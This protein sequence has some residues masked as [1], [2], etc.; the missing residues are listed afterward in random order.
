MLQKGPDYYLK[1]KKDN[2]YLTVEG[3]EDGARVVAKEKTKAQ[4]Q[5]FRLDHY[6]PDSQEYI[7]Y[8]YCGKVLDVA[9][10]SEDNGARIIQWEYSGDKNQRWTLCNPNEITSSSSELEE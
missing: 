6:E 9:E 2:L 3:D 1:C 4:N 7:I 8:T 5:R 10:A